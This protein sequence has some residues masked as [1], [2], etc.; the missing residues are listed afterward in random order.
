MP[1]HPTSVPPFAAGPPNRIPPAAAAGPSP[2]VPAGAAL[3]EEDIHNPLRRLGFFFALA[4]VFVRFTTLHEVLTVKLGFNP[5]LLYWVGGPAILFLILTGGLQRSWYWTPVRFWL[6]YLAWIYAAIPTSTWRSDSLRLVF[7][8]SRTELVVLF[9][10]AGLVLTWQECW[11]TL[12]WLALAAFVLVLLG[13]F[14]S[15]Q[16]SPEDPRLQLVAGTMSN[17]NDYAALMVIILPFVTL[18]VIA[19]GVAVLTRLAAALVFI[20]GLYLILATGSRGALVALVVTA[21][22]A[23]FRLP[24]AAK[25]AGLLLLSVLAVLLWSFLPDRITTRLRTI[26]AT[27]EDVD[28]TAADSASAR[29][30]L[31][32]QSIRFTLERP[33]FG[34]GP[35][36]FANFEGS[37]ARQEGERGS[38]HDTHN[39]YTQVSSEAGIPAFIFYVGAILSTGRLLSRVY[40]RARSQPP[41][42]ENRRIAAACLCVMLAFVGFATSVMFLSLAYRFYL[43][44]LSG[45]AIAIARATDHLWST[46]PP[47][48]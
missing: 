38:W 25:I 32:R 5:F 43:P 15:E 46:P 41:T 27:N 44:A 2:L 37:I 22:Y 8:Y 40:K 30:Y 16:L 10:I 11:R 28:M 36:Q 23:L 31:L 19:P 47:A 42:L 24:L 20:Y 7:T 6:L 12:R 26:S 33:L 48:S 4:F 17:S 29:L 1:N 3:Q 35:G 34:V 9:L 39:A 14:F 18:F 21:I 13:H 45:L